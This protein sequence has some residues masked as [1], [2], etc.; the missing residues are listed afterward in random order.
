[1][2]D[3]DNLARADEKKGAQPIPA[4]DQGGLARSSTPS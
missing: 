1:V 2:T 4:K 3:F